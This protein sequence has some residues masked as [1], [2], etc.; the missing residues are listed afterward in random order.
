LSIN[1]FDLLALIESL[2]NL[3]PNQ[4]ETPMTDFLK[5]SMPTEIKVEDAIQIISDSLNTSENSV[6]AALEN[7]S[8]AIA[9]T[10]TPNLNNLLPTP[11]SEVPESDVP[12]SKP[13][14]LPISTPPNP[15]P[16][17]DS[18]MSS[19]IGIQ[20][21]PIISS[22]THKLD[23]ATR[24]MIE[25][26][27]RSLQTSVIHSYQSTDIIDEGFSQTNLANSAKANSVRKSENSDQTI[28]EEK[29][30]ADRKNEEMREE[31]RRARFKNSGKV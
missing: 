30:R 6:K 28:K 1:T 21:S 4:P 18:P 16:L 26:I 10:E 3:I 13:A 20:V 19:G 15:A 2:Q 17:T 12:V 5:D 27:A 14:N 9:N 11:V 23:E 31:L 7:I 25:E 29:R 24:R 8:Q 22:S